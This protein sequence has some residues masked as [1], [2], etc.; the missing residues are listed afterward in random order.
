MSRP[1][2]RQL[3]YAVAVADELHFR[4]AAERCAVSQPALSTQIQ[5]L[6]ELLGVQIFERT[7]RQ[8]RL[9]TVGERVVARA[10]RVLRELDELGEV[11][12]QASAP[13]STPVTLGV[14]PT[15]AP[16]LLPRILPAVRARYP[17][18][19][20]RLVED[21][22]ARLV[23]ALGAGQLDL[24]LLALP[25]PGG[26]GDVTR[27]LFDERFY[28]AAP[29]DH[30]LTRL[31]EIDERELGGRDVL[32]LED[33]HCLREHALSVCDAAGARA[34]GAVRA[35]SLNTLVHMVASGLGITLLPEMAVEAAVAAEGRVA[36]RRFREPA[37]TRTIGLS[38]RR[39]SARQLEFE[40]LADL[41]REA[42]EQRSPIT[43]RA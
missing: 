3:E 31:D 20:L 15:V 33:G 30:P 38:W 36:V 8:V 37:P 42:W 14:I 23:A 22:T 5:Q 21:R 10:R 27:P 12:R 34:A 39:S 35:T 18:L 41:I 2:I 11:A 25:I 43:G 7:R 28:L 32:L 40:L 1:T 17:A 4:R 19:E 24:L 16:Y 26:T 29:P 6:E 9:T 13:L